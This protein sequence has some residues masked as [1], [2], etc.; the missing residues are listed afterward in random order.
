MAHPVN[1]IYAH[2]WGRVMGGGEIW[3]NTLC[4]R[5]D[6]ALF[7]PHVAVHYREA[8]ANTLSAQGVPVYTFPVQHL[9]LRPVIRSPLASGAVL[10]SG[11]RLFRAAK[12]LDAKLIHAFSLEAAQPGIIAA[13]LANIPIVVSVLNSGPFVREDKLVFSLV[14]ATIVNAYSILRDIRA[15]GLKHTEVHV[16]PLGID[17]ARFVA[18]T[19]QGIRAEFQLATSDPLIGMV[20]NIEH[21]KGYDILIRAASDLV[22]AYPHVKFLLVGAD[23]SEGGSETRRL[24]QMIGD[25][26]L[27]QHFIFMGARPDV[28]AVLAAI[29]IFVLCSRAEGL[30]VAMVEAMAAGKPVIVTPVGGTAEAVQHGFNGLLIPPEDPAALAD[31]LH[32]LLAD[33]ERARQM[34]HAGRDLV[35]QR[36]DAEACVRQTEAVYR[37]LLTSAQKIGGKRKQVWRRAPQ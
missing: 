10:Y 37:Q 25:L 8:L 30:S 31:G 32:D 17:T 26:G 21:R 33:P 29:D 7:T 16:I 11:W 19:G 14:D 36:F 18:A 12:R 4:R 9:Q 15:A 24:Q 35:I 1:I 34:G 5:L 13:R 23:N 22:R 27:T 2:R 3:L 28:P 6:S 20:G